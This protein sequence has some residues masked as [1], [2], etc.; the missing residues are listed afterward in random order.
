MK[1]KE[2]AVEIIKGIE[3]FNDTKIIYRFNLLCFFLPC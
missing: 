3:K 1:N 2:T